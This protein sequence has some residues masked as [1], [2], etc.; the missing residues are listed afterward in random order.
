MTVQPGSTTGVPRLFA[1][2]VAR[3]PDPAAG[4]QAIALE[5]ELAASAGTPYAVTVSSGTAAIHTALRACG[6]GPGDEVL[7]PTLTVIMVIAAVIAA[8]AQPVL[9]DAGSVDEPLDLDDLAAKVTPRTRAVLPVH[10]AGRTGDMS[11][12][13]TLA[14]AHG[15]TVIED[16]CQAQGSLYWGRLA[17]TFGKA[18]CFSLK[19][20]KITS[21]GEGGY[22]LTSDPDVA[23]RAAAFR[24]HGTPPNTSPA[25]RTTLGLN[26][27]LA[28]P[29]AALARDSLARQESAVAERHRQ[30]GLLLSLVGDVPGLEPVLPAP[31]EQLNGYASLWHVRLCG[32]RGFCEHLAAHRVPNSTGSFGFRAASADPACAGLGLA[33]CSRAEALADSLLAGPVTSRTTSDQIARMASVIA[34]EGRRAPTPTSSAT[35]SAQTPPAL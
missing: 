14:A 1:E 7:V 26:Y 8:G 21:C 17:G 23:F 6:I 11:A 31:G 28:E 33:P 13:T 34:A 15:L 24:N 10:F 29:L 16:A 19:D 25:A 9:V 32:P 4:H 35:T 3:M 2:A 22:L 20:G 18:G 5:A 30:T 27:R 12:L